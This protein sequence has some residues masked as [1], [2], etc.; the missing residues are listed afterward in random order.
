MIKMEIRSATISYSKSKSKRIRN[1]ERDILWKLGLLDN[2]I[3][4]NFSSPD[5]DDTLQEYENLKFELKS[6]YEEKGKQAMFRAKCRSL[7]NGE[8][9]TKYFFNLEKRNYNKKTIRELRRQDE[10]IKNN[11]NE[12]LDQIETF[13]KKLYTSEGI[14]SDE[15]YDSF[16]R[17]LEIPTLK[18]EDR[19]TRES[20][21][22]YDECR[23]ALET[24]QNDKAPGEDGFTIEFY[25]YFFDLLG[26][27]LLASFN[28]AHAKGELS[29][30]QRRG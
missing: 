23:K 22:T 27:D 21:L 9:P 30:S 17:D 18:D 10:S 29:I 28:E 11:E 13:Y 6:I 15:E 12:I 14:F 20:P 25:K 1:R 5:I 7:E 8:R 3:C 26:N 19:D 16:I 24:F 4:N 2:T